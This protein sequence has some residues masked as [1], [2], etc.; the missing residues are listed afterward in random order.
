VG[1]NLPEVHPMLAPQFAHWCSSITWGRPHR[2]RV[3]ASSGLWATWISVR[4]IDMQVTLHHYVYVY[5]SQMISAICTTWWQVPLKA[6][7][8]SSEITR[9]LCMVQHVSAERSRGQRAYHSAS[10]AQSPKEQGSVGVQSNSFRISTSVPEVVSVI[11]MDTRLREVASKSNP[12][13]RS[14]EGWW[15]PLS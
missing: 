1:M 2:A 15:S 11:L 3:S 12:A 4:M 8:I 9:S 13:C 7:G 14:T 6:R 10:R 5:G